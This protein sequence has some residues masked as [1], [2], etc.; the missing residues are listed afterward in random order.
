MRAN[1]PIPLVKPK[2]YDFLNAVFDSKEKARQS[3][4]KYKNRLE[5][6]IIDSILCPDHSIND[7]TAPYYISLAQTGSMP[8]DIFMCDYNLDAENKQDEYNISFLAT[9]PSQGLFNL[10][11]FAIDQK[12]Y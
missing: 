4:D 1:T 5:V 8:R 7:S 2:N 6:E 9:K 10:K 12:K 11:T 3:V